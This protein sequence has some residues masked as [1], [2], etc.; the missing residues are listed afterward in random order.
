M[1]IA[2]YA[3]KDQ[4]TASHAWVVLNVAIGGI[5]APGGAFT[6][7]SLLV[8]GW[9]IIDTGGLNRTVGWVGVIAGVL[10]VWS[11]FATTSPAVFLG[12]LVFAIVWLAWAGSELRRPYPASGTGA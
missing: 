6:G 2:D 3:T 12:S 10:S 4:V 1:R 11:L 9:A 7:A 8:A 5:N